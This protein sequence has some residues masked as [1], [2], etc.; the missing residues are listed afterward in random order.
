MEAAYWFVV[1]LF[2]SLIKI[3]FYNRIQ[4]LKPSDYR[5][6]IVTTYLYYQESI[7]S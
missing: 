6:L 3:Q 7:I 4:F 1:K 2:C 5:L